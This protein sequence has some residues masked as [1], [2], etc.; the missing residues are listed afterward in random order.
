MPQLLFDTLK[1]A[2]GYSQFRHGQ[3]EVIQACLSGQ[4]TF[5]L[6]P[7][8]GGKSLC[9][10]LPA[11]LLPY[12]TV[13]VSPLMSLMKDQV[14]ALQANGI[15]AEF[16][17]SSQSREEIQDVIRRLRNQQ[18]KLLYLAPERLL[19]P[20]FMSRLAEVGVSLFAIDEAH[21]ISQWGHDFRP[22]YTELAQLKQ[23]FA[24]VPMMAL[25]ATADPATQ[26]DISRQLNLQQPYVSIGSFDRPNIRYTVQEKFRPLEQV[27]NY[28]KQQE[29]QSGIIYCASRRKVDELTEQ[30]ASKGFQVAA[31]HAGLTNEQRNSVQEAF[32]KDQI[33]LIIATV[34]FGMGVNKSNIRFVIHFELPR[35]IEAYYQETGRAGRDGVPAEAL[36]L[37]DPAD[38]ARMRSWIEKDENNSRTEVALQRFNQMAAFAQA[39]TCRRLVLLNY[40]GESSQKPCGNCDIC[41]DPPKQFDATELA[42]K[43]LSCVY[44]V[45][46]SFGM[47]H[48]I[49]VLR[50]SQTSRIHE[51]GHDKLSTFAIG[52]DQSHDYWLS[53]LRQL[54]HCGLLQ[55]DISQHSVLKL[56]EAARAVLRAEQKLQLAVPRLVQTKASSSSKTAAPQ[57]YDRKLFARLKVLRK[58]IAERDDVPPFVVFSDATLIEMAQA[59]PT[60]SLEFLAISGVGQTKLGRYGADFL[61]LISDY[62]AGD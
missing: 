1:Q 58:S 30:L 12:V 57:N 2:F 34:A 5:V 11:L 22:H 52:K 54:V 45:N 41:V 43:A 19:Q 24:H 56:Q 16:I 10:Q 59:C 36:M 32:K 27:V 38:I 62:L 26:K 35:T 13:V 51:L 14:D 21:C 44:R 39:Q 29:Q 46:Q 7:T 60:N 49:D 4:D 40:F 31:Y 37:V 17:N 50:G 48:V 33:Q 20:D 6:M 9:Y 42:R 53:I 3:L 23:Y 47:N 28:L 18:L 15:A 8:G 25:T 55:Q 61:D